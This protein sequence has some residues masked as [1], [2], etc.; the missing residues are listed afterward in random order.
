MKTQCIFARYFLKLCKLCPLLAVSPPLQFLAQSFNENLCSH[1]VLNLLFVDCNLICLYQPNL[2]HCVKYG[3]V[4]LATMAFQNFYIHKTCCDPNRKEQFRHLQKFPTHLPG[5][6]IRAE[7]LHPQQESPFPLQ[8]TEST[9]YKN[10][11]L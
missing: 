4:V 8:A 2:S 6:G 1:F 11:F 9:F 5:S 3:K 7:V 10:P